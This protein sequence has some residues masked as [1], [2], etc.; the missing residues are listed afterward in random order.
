MESVWKQEKWRN[1]FKT[2]SVKKHFHHHHSLHHHHLAPFLSSCDHDSCAFFAFHEKLLSAFSYSLLT[3]SR[4][5][6]SIMRI[7][8]M[9]MMLMSAMG[10]LN[11]TRKFII[12]CNFL[13]YLPPLLKKILG[14]FSPI[15]QMYLIMRTNVSNNELMRTNQTNCI[16]VRLCISANLL[17]GIDNC[18]SNK[19]TQCKCCRTIN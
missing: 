13:K 14:S 3:M 10:V 15:W 17:I 19:G 18:C 6:T 4:M 1:P 16:F 2:E 11:M 5:M 7:V 9:M 8:R 12:I